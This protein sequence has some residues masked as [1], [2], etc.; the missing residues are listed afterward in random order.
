MGRQ[1]GNK[2]KDRQTNVRYYY[3]GTSCRQKD[4]EIGIYEQTN[5]LTYRQMDRQ[6]RK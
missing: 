3:N 6:I 1:I 4:R 5:R 2:Q